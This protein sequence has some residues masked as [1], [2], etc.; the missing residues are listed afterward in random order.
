VHEAYLKLL[1]RDDVPWREPE[2]FRAFVSSA[3]RRI[4]VDH[5]RRRSASKRGGG[6]VPVTLQAEYVAVRPGTPDLLA[7]DDALRQLG[8]LDARLERVVECRFFGGLGVKETAQALGISLRTAER[9]WTRAKAHLR[10]LLDGAVT[11]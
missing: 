2:R 8:Q 7:L 11:T 5:A 4:L 10:R 9:D 6:V 1:H 3:M